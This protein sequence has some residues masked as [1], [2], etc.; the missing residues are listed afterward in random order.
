MRRR[1]TA[2][3]NDEATAV[4]F[5]W[6]AAFSAT[7]TLIAVLGI[8]KSAQALTVPSTGFPGPIAAL[9]AS[10]ADEE[11]EAEEAEI[12]EDEG[13]GEE[14][15]EDE[16]ECE[17]EDGAS[18]DAP[19]DCLLSSAE[20]TISANANKDRV[21]LQ[22][23]YTTSSPTDVTVEYGLH[24]S[25]GSLFLGGEKK[26]FARQGVLRLTKTLTEAQMAKA[27][28]AKVFTVRF[29]VPATPGYCKAFF[30]YQLDSRHATPSG[31]RWEQAE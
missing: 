7:L 27:M 30:D 14:C 22:V 3:T 28:A 25:K 11:S 31:L 29:R 12:F 23:R 13:S 10:P 21:R 26:R 6:W 1:V 5:A 8:A 24:G 15:E 17:E 19:A 2:A 16:E 4:R 20:A 18:A 9:A